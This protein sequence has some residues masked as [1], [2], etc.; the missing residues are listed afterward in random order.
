[1]QTYGIRKDLGTIMCY[2]KT[3][4]DHIPIAKVF[5]ENNSVYGTP[6]EFELIKTPID[7][8]N[9][10]N[11][12]LCNHFLNMINWN[13]HRQLYSI[14]PMQGGFI[15]LGKNF[16]S[17]FEVVSQDGVE[18]ITSYATDLLRWRRCTGMVVIQKS[19]RGPRFLLY[20]YDEVFHHGSGF[21]T[22]CN[23]SL[24]YAREIIKEHVNKKYAPYSRVFPDLAGLIYS[25][26]LCFL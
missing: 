14:E 11:K 6:R 1:M 22:D 18:R 10:M 16:I 24:E 20:L 26:N 5:V 2:S 8:V 15:D 21:G 12:I 25:D 17:T 19:N 7:T 3:G 23:L 9:A 13:M 4:K